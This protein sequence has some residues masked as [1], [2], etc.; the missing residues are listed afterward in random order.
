MWVGIAHTTGD[1]I[2]CDADMEVFDPTTIA[3][4]AAP[5]LTDPTVGL[6][7]A[8][9]V[10]HFGQD[11]RDDAGLGHGGRNTELVVRA[12]MSNQFSDLVPGLWQLQQPLE[13]LMALRRPIAEQL[14]IYS[15]YGVE[16]A[17]N[18]H[19]ADY[20]GLEAIAQAETGKRVNANKS[21]Q[22]LAKQGYEIKV[23]ADGLEAVMRGMQVPAGRSK[24]F[25]RPNLE[26]WTARDGANPALVGFTAY[27]AR[28]QEAGRDVLAELQAWRIR[29]DHLLPHP[30]GVEE[31]VGGRDPRDELGCSAP[32]VSL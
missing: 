22:E 3:T 30:L 28:Q 24:T 1:I 8:A 21:N 13:G 29:H 6:V 2:F 10:R 14:A 15:G 26:D 18:I 7:K 20:W 9:S 19:V 32:E 16:I 12:I 25:R 27:V 17:M 5:L 4:V 31:Q 11:K 23:V